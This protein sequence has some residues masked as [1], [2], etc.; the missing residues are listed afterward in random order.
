MDIKN[1]KQALKSDSSSCSGD[2]SAAECGS[3][4]DVRHEIDRLDQRLIELLADRQ[5]YIEA[6]ARI[7]KDRGTVRDPSRIEDV[8]QKVVAH[9]R[10][11][12]LNPTIAE[13]VWRALIEQCIVHEFNKYDAEETK[14]SLEEESQT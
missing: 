10:A 1:L 5:T 2:K 6:A 12:G 3:M 11:H 8:V 14:E 4:E 7:K 9:A 13:A